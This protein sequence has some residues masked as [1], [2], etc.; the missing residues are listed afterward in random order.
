M[1]ALRLS[2]ALRVPNAPHIPASG[3]RQI[4]SLQTYR[5]S[6]TS[7]IWISRRPQGIFHRHFQHLAQ[8]PQKPQ[9]GTPSQPPPRT[10]A[11]PAAKPPAKADEV[12]HISLAQQR[13]NDWNI[14]KRLSGNLWPKDDW[15]T[16]GRVVVGMGL[17]VAGKVRLSRPV[18]RAIRGLLIIL[19][20]AVE[21]S[22]TAGIQAD[23][24]YTEHSSY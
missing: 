8:D 19:P 15:S 16:R 6:Q 3:G 11:T 22:S 17:L 24:R 2:R 7:S 5:S 12:V 21:C 10:P 4:S 20:K 18:Q 13:K 1:N 14:I 23:H 9:P